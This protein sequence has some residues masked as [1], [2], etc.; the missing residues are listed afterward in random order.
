M[1][2]TVPQW[3]L[4]VWNLQDHKRF[5]DV[6]T[7]I[8]LTSWPASNISK[9]ICSTNIAIIIHCGLSS[10]SDRRKKVKISV[11]NKYKYKFSSHVKTERVLTTKADKRGIKM[12][13]RWWPIFLS[14]GT[15]WAGSW[16]I[17]TIVLPSFNLYWNILV[18]AR[19]E[20]ERRFVT[21][22]WEGCW[23]FS[24]DQSCRAL[25]RLSAHV[26]QSLPPPSSLSTSHLPPDITASSPVIAQ[27]NLE[28]AMPWTTPDSVWTLGSKTVTTVLRH[29]TSLLLSLVIWSPVNNNNGK[30][31]SISQSNSK[32]Q[33]SCF[34]SLHRGPFL[35]ASDEVPAVVVI[36]SL[37][38]VAR[39]VC[40]GRRGRG[41]SGG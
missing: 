39:C 17:C 20:R 27:L 6:L 3:D 40:W 33:R 28:T 38:G 8:L 34:L 30:Y 36:L 25:K 37:C 21:F 19:E 23:I 12:S 10:H 14:D 24:Y 26:Q 41:W 4:S 29:A 31:Y 16:Y 22:D 7:V 32:P 5:N 9:T 13:Y 11:N 18:V 35:P 1:N 2:Q 15:Y